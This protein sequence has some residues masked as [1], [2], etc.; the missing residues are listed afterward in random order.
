MLQT[1]KEAI[2]AKLSASV[3]EA[4]FAVDERGTRKPLQRPFCCVTVRKMEVKVAAAGH[5]LGF[6]GGA[7]GQWADVTLG[8]SIYAPD[9][10]ASCAEI[11]DRLCGALL[12]DDALSL[13]EFSC[14]QTEYLVKEGA[15]RLEGQA[16]CRTLLCVGGTPDGEVSRFSLTVSSTA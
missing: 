2:C 3:P 6:P 14:G 5:Y 7:R 15:F 10:A 9:Q 16:R 1:L 12:F 13:R 11:F 8:F 4:L